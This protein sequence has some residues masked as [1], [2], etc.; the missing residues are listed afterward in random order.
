MLT[1]NYS[2]QRSCIDRKSRNCRIMQDS[3]LT[4][5]R[6]VTRELARAGISLRVPAWTVNLIP[7]EA[8]Y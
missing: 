8:Q 6:A 1:L 4:P 3:A 2:I 7:R 5:W